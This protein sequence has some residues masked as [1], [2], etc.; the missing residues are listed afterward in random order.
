MYYNAENALLF[1]RVSTATMSSSAKTLAL[2]GGQGVGGIKPLHMQGIS[3]TKPSLSL[4]RGLHTSPTRCH[5][6]GFILPY[7]YVQNVLGAPCDS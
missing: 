5:S 4:Y 2:S 3:A 6:N 1:C 7:P